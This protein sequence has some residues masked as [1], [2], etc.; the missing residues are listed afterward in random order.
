MNSHTI[1]VRDLLTIARVRIAVTVAVAVVVL[2]MRIQEIPVA[3]LLL[4]VQVTSIATLTGDSLHC[5]TSVLDRD[6]N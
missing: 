6:F 4:P 1:L 3:T 5:Q 2:V